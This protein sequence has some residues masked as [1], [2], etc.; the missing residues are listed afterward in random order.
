M[1]LAEYVSKHT[2]R[3]SCRC[4]NC[5]ASQGTTS[6]G[7]GR[8][9]GLTFFDVYARCENDKAPVADE[10]RALIESHKGE[11]C[12]CNP[13]DGNEHGYMELGG[14]LGSQD[15][16]LRF[17]GLCDLL[18]LGKAMTPETMMPFLDQDTKLRMAQGGMVTLKSL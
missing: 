16:A 17:I 18:G 1:N 8:A 5:I 4:G 7:V 3:T 15:L 10:L 6:D 2:D 12:A 11:F 9:V 13:L 14:W